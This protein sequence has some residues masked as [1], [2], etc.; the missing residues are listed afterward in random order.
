MLTLRTF[1]ILEIRIDI[2]PMFFYEKKEN[3]NLKSLIC[4]VVLGIL[5]MG[6]GIVVSC[7]SFNEDLP[8]CRLLVKFKYDYNMEFADAFHA[9]VDKVELYIF[10]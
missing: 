7:D 6:S 8:E 1:S 9:Q 10:D 2:L 5:L 4:Y 3:M